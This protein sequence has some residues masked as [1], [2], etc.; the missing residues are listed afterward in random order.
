MDRKNKMKKKVKVREKRINLG[1]FKILGLTLILTLGVF[2]AFSSAYFT[3][4]GITQFK[5]SPYFYVKTIKITGTR[6]TPESKIMDII[7]N[8]K[9]QLNIFEA[10]LSHIRNTILKE[11]WIKDVTVRR[12]LPDTI[13]VEVQERTP[14]A[15]VRLADG[16]YLVDE[17]GFVF[18]KADGKFQELPLVIGEISREDLSSIK[19]IIDEYK[20]LSSS[21]PKE[22]LFD[23]SKI[24]ITDLSGILLVFDKKGMENMKY[25]KWAFDYIRRSGLSPITI[26]MSY[27]KKAILQF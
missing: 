2:L 9:N 12:I 21:S 13:S 11:S 18:L 17:D 10:D 6:M 26:D 8:G 5:N 14:V 27:P 20:R 1:P 25:V 3:S 23:N 4:R 24:R 19:K 7:K 22:I 15:R 16:E